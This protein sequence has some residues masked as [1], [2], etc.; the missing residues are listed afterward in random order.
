MLYLLLV[1]SLG[2]GIIIGRA[3]KRKKPV[4]NLVIDNSDPDGPYMFLELTA[5]PNTELNDKEVTF[6]VVHKD[7]ISQK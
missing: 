5:D 2:L 4:G 7:Y 1:V 6:T 3:L